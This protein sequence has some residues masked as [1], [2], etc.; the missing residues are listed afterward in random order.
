MFR[1][2]RLKQLRENKG[3][4]HAQ[5]AEMLEVGFAQIY[6]FETN[7][8]P[9]S[10]T[11]AKMAQIFNV[12]SDYLLGLTHD[13]SPHFQADELTSQERKILTALRQGNGMEAIRLIA[14]GE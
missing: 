4:T 6:R 2:D 1:G 5:L 11:V 12:S 13:P 14:S 9:S 10:D 7:K 3:Y 8:Q